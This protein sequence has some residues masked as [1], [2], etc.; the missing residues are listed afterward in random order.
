M[1]YDYEGEAQAAVTG[2]WDGPK[3]RIR[4]AVSLAL[5]PPF[6][7]PKLAVIWFHM[8]DSHWT[9]TGIR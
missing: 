2:F 5:S 6:L 9:I 7:N 4:P 8:P 3:F 1:E